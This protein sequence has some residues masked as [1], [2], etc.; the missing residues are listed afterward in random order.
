MTLCDPSAELGCARHLRPVFLK[1][2]GWPCLWE[3]VVC[4]AV[5]RRGYGRAVGV[6]YLGIPWNPSISPQAACECVNVCVSQYLG[7]RCVHGGV[8]AC[9]HMD[10]WGECCRCP[11]CPGMLGRMSHGA[12]CH[13]E[14]LG[15]PWSP[16]C[17]CPSGL[18]PHVASLGSLTVPK[19]SWPAMCSYYPMFAEPPGG[20]GL[21][22]G[23]ATFIV[24][25]CVPSSETGQFLGPTLTFLM[26]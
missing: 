5:L 14:P 6:R 10:T 13:V 9:I 17:G 18:C 20:C 1:R 26:S 4:W 3:R 2:L 7:V 12:S 25:C 15:A 24:S 16:S 21:Q 19:G 11:R 23:R 8:C 22:E